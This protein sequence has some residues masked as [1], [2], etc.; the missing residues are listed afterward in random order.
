MTV[1]PIFSGA[2]CPGPQV[3]MLT[4]FIILGLHRAAL[5]YTSTLPHAYETYPRAY[6]G[7][8]KDPANDTSGTNMLTYRS[9]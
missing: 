6:Y 1:N 8:Y 9:V 4:V 3:T 5:E 7:L 2:Y